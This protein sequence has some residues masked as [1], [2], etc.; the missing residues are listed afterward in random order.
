MVTL[1]E[2]LGIGGFILG[3]A[4]LIIIIIKS[5]KDRPI[6]KIEKKQYTKDYIPEDYEESPKYIRGLIVKIYNK[7]NKD[8]FLKNVS[9]LYHREEK[10]PFSPNLLNPHFT[11][12]KISVRNME[13]VHL[14]FEFRDI[15]ILEDIEKTLPI[16]I[17]IEF[18]FAHKKI[19][20][21][22]YVGRPS[23]P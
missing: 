17:V 4:N 15:K 23:I 5:A 12:T 16:K 10:T 3:I 9:A 14:F 18:E 8:A 11:K 1:I 13:E 20:K 19:K 7:G 6:I 22:F 2:L 21:E